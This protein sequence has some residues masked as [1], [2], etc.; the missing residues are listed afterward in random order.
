MFPISTVVKT[1][2]SALVLCLFMVGPVLAQDAS[3]PNHP[4]KVTSIT[5]ANPQLHRGVDIELV[6]EATDPED[7]DISF[8]YQW[9]INGTEI[10]DNNS[11]VLPGNQIQRDDRIAVM[12][13][14]SDGKDTGLTF[15]T[16]EFV[17]PNAP[18][19]IVSDKVPAFNGNKFE[20]QVEAN[21][22]DDDILTFSLEGAP[23]GMTIDAQTG[24]I[25]WTRE[26]GL[27]GT[28]NINIR[29]SDP[30]GAQT[31][32]TLTIELK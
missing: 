11:A 30:L 9:F 4:P 22:P 29:I 6:L 25:N 27:Q 18:P 19:V 2:L 10:A 31:T 12:I 13:T 3:G 32:A 1:C 5:L 15:S 7:D 14:P 8:A 24:K 17:I 28:Y 23:E 20:Y 26:P 21:D 16:K